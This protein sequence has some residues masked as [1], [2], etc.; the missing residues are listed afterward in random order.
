MEGAP[1]IR[2]IGNASGEEK[3]KAKDDIKARLFSH[4]ESLKPKEKDELERLEYPK[5]PTEFALINFAN[6]ETNKLMMEVGVGA[7]DIPEENYHIIPSE[8]YEK[9]A[10]S[11]GDAVTFTTEQGVLFDASIFRGN[12]AIFGSVAVHETLHLKA[13]LSLEVNEEDGAMEISR[14]NC[15]TQSHRDSDHNM[16]HP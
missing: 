16:Y 7:Y 8:L 3:A 14:W 1:R 2:T 11:Y 5:T 13:H 4:F 6:K 12:P 10:G 9:A 15:P